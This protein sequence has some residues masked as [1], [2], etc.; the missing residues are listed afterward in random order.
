MDWR[1][2]R[3]GARSPE[4]LEQLL[5]DAILLG[6]RAA[7]AQL[8]EDDGV[9]RAGC[10]PYLPGYVADPRRV[11]RARGLALVLGER[12]VT[13]ARRQGDGRWQYAFAVL[14]DAGP[15]EEEMEHTLVV[16]MSAD[17]SRRDDVVRHLREDVVPWARSRPGFVAGQWLLDPGGARGAGVL[18]FDSRESA[19]QAA[20]GPRGYTRDET[21]A[22]N[23][24]AVEVYE[25]VGAATG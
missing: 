11:L 4:D 12:S 19:E 3:A 6:D 18:V 23:V 9:L 2:D 24:E 16:R 7:V 20:R 17:P 8:V 21:R 22:W 25:Q 1:S 10:G 5:E 15:E 13:V 14:R